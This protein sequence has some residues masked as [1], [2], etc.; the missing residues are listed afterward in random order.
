[1]NNSIII[2]G[3][4]GFIGSNVVRQ[5]ISQNIEVH[6]FDNLSTGR[7]NNLNLKCE[8]LFF[9]DIDLKKDYTKWPQIKSNKLFHFAANADVRGGINDH[10]IDFNENTLVTK[11]ICDYC[12][13]NNIKELIFSSSATVYGEPDLFP[14]PENSSL[15]QTSLYGASKLACEAFIQAY[16][17]YGIFKSSIFRFVSWT[18]IGYSHG[19]IYDFVKKLILDPTKL[20]IL[21]DGLQTKS[22]LDV[23]DGV[24]GVIDLSNSF[25]KGSKVF[26][27]GHYET[28]NVK[29]LADIVCNE[30]GLEDVTYV[31]TGGKRGWIGDAPF[32]HLDTNKA[33]DAGWKPKISIKDS[34]VSTV[35]FLIDNR[36]N[37]YR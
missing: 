12:Q 36:D 8:N 20:E 35:R 27:L 2:T 17:E 31:F 29:D 13:L 4:A 7:L 9:Y 5:L 1:M 10:G 33:Q 6:V 32:V 22:Y 26:N 18:G 19:V 30:M 24:R 21:G 28:M 14:T 23:S 25:D 16:S 3:G 34:I 15:I 37:L 11:S